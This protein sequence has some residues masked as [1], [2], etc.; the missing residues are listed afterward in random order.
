[1]AEYMRNHTSANTLIVNIESVPAIAALDE[2]LAVPGLDGVLIGPHDLS[3]SLGVPEQYSHPKFMEAVGTIFKK[4]RSAGIGAGIHWWGTPEEQAQF[5]KL[6]ANFIIHSG[7]ITLFQ[8]HLRLE[9][10][11]IRKAAGI[12]ATSAGSKA[13]TI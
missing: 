13:E 10:Q 12:S 6:G 1:L 5:H 8:K 9:I 7:D 11:G 2:I 3:C 4:A